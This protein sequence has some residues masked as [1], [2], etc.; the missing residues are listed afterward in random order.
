[1]RAALVERAREGDEG[2]LTKVPLRGMSAATAIAAS[3]S[4]RIGHGGSL[5]RHIE[6]L[7]ASAG[8]RP[9]CGEWGYSPVTF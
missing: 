5:A 6:R 8:R 4:R 7:L 3:P 1:M 2:A 9:E